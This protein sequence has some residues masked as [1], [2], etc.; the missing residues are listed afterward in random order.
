M[1]QKSNMKNW[2]GLYESTIHLLLIKLNQFMTV[3]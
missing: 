1:D 2:I 3:F